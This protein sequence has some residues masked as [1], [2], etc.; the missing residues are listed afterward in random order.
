MNR[1]P[2]QRKNV[3]AQP[4]KK[5]SITVPSELVGWLD[6]KIADRTFATLSHAIEVCVLEAQKRDK[7]T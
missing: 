5:I 1:M 7:K 4:R 2:R 3:K 6:S